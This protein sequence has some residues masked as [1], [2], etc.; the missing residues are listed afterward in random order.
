MEV[1][2]L[3]FEVF[4]RTVA[5]LYPGRDA[6]GQHNPDT[7]EMRATLLFPLEEVSPED[8]VEHVDEALTSQEFDPQIEALEMLRPQAKERIKQS[9]LNDIAT[10]GMP[11][12]GYDFAVDYDIND[13]LIW[14]GG[15]G[16]LDPEATEVEVRSIDD[17]YHRRQAASDVQERLSAITGLA[18]LE[19]GHD[20]A[21]LANDLVSSMKIAGNVA[22]IR[23]EKLGRSLCS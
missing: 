11:V 12:P 9:W 14:S 1:N 6:F 19:M 4:M 22:R 5:W 7:D 2:G 3:T 23:Q 13:Y 16:L 10:V 17:Q 18:G 21:S 8:V 15:V 20:Y